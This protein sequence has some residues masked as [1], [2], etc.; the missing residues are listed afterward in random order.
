MLTPD[1]LELG[2]QAWRLLPDRLIGYP[3]R[4]HYMENN[5]W[6]YDATWSND[7]SI[8]LTG[9]AFYHNYFNYVYHYHTPQSLLDYVDSDMNCEDILMNF[10]IQNATQKA[11]IKVTPRKFF[12]SPTQSISGHKGH[13]HTRATCLN[14]MVETYGKMPLQSIDFRVDPVL[15]NI[16]GTE[17]INTFN[18][19]G[20]L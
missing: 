1:E 11:P 3:S 8:I 19:V 16:E 9:A 15:Y 13:I 2:Y 14:V 4:W 5:K 10:V 12:K 6:V 17:D 7:A 18:N 20:S